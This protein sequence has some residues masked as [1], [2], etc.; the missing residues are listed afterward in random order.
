VELL[1]DAAIQLLVFW[2][3]AMSFLTAAVPFTVTS[4]AQRFWVFYILANT[5]YF[6]FLLL[7]TIAILEGV[8]WHLT[9]WI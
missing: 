3:P 8:K 9:V 6:L 7:F 1:N 4:D 2:R 5:Y